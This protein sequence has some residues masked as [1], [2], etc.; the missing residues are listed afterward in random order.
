MRPA[1]TVLFMGIFIGAVATARAE[2]SPPYAGQQQREIKALSQ[3]EIGG[4]LEGNGM[5]FAKAAELNGYPGPLHV[6][7]LATELE[8]TAEQRERTEALFDAMSNE[9][10]ALGHSLVEEERRLDE[11]F[12]TNRATPKLL[13]ESLKRIG[14]L[15]AKLRA[16][17]LYAHL[18]QRRILTA[19]QSGVYARLRGYASGETRSGHGTHH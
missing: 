5:G 3:S 6:L 15:R 18:E 2:S 11:L 9:A 13:D 17:H 8:L 16:V 12:A 4:L 10:K 1:H 7:Q 19:A 14:L